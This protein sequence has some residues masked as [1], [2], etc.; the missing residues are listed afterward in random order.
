[1]RSPGYLRSN[2]PAHFGTEVV[3]TLARQTD[4]IQAGKVLWGGSITVPWEKVLVHSLTGA[5]H[6]STIRPCT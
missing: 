3:K 2:L 5:P 6:L 1:M 4:H